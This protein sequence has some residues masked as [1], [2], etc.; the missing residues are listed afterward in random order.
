LPH[1]PQQR[2]ELLVGRQVRRPGEEVEALVQQV[3]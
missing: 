1:L 2:P 3:L